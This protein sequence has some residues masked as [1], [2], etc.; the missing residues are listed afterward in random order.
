MSGAEVVVE[1]PHGDRGEVRDLA[2]PDIEALVELD[3]QLFA[4]DAWSAATWWAELAE[5]P[6]RDYAV[7]TQAGTVTAYGGVGLGSDAADIMTL[8]VAPQAQGRGL[9]AR[10]L[11]ELEAR[12][13][14]AGCDHGLLEVRADNEA[15]RRLY[16][17][18]GW[19][20]LHRRRRYYQP[21]DVD[22]IIMGKALA[23]GRAGDE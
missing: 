22:A 12:A 23:G 13:R 5:R 10:V 21:G 4:D 8:A 20:E 18:A 17:G 7:W 2:W 15:A 16:E 11:G 1:P 6:R 19:R 14:R 9:G 3:A